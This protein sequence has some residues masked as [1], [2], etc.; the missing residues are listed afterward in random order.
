MGGIRF[1]LAA[2]C[3]LASSLCGCLAAPD[4]TFSI[5]SAPVQDWGGHNELS[6]RFESSCENGVLLVWG[7]VE[8][9]HLRR[10]QVIGW[11][12]IAIVDES[13]KRWRE[14]HANYREPVASDPPAAAAVFCARVDTPPPPGWRVVVEHHPRVFDAR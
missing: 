5:G 8:G 1:A 14:L 10:G 12:N 2:A 13:G 11:A 3:A 6:G 7:T 9:P 4:P